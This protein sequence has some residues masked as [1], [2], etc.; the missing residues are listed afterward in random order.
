MKTLPLTTK[1][2]TWVNMTPALM[3]KKADE[4]IAHKK[5]I[6]KEIKEILPENRTFE[7]TL[8][9]LERCDDKFESFFS[10]MG[11]LSEV[12]PKKDVRDA[13][14]AVATEMSQKLVDIEYDRDLY[15]SLVE[16]YEGNFLDEKKSL[17][18]EDIKLL[19]ETIRE[20]RRMGFD[21]DETK[22]KRLKI[23]LKK[24]SKLSI[25]FRQ[26]INDYQDYIVCTEE[27]L[28]GMSPRF[29]QS[30]PRHT[31]VRQCTCRQCGV[32]VTV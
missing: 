31:E 6:Y 11:L 29:T 17:R 2:F 18:K 28:A 7:N 10:K 23:L 15:I 8:Y 14:H 3:K 27:E 5:N 12:S 20:Y 25:M 22:Q 16:Y 24:S 32:V 30:L 21:L 1:D 19:E 4:Y 13:A 26:N 9:A